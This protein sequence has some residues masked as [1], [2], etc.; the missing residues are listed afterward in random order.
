M[1]KAVPAPQRGPRLP[2]ASARGGGGGGLVEYFRGV[3]DELRKV[4]WPTREE[5]ARMTGIVIATVI[6]FAVI[7]GGADYLLSLGV[8]QIYTGSA[9]STTTTTT[10]PTLSPP[11]ATQAPAASAP[12]Q[13]TPV[14]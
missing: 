9:N 11:A 12:A 6:L 3:L 8:K 13:S 2:V 7:I 10:N 1:A 14:P 5:L 4:V